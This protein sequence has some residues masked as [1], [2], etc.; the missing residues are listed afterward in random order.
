VIDDGPVIAAGSGA[1]RPL[2]VQRA[3]RAPMSAE[4]LVRG[5]PIAKGT[6]LP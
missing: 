4:E 2:Q 5:F 1:I 3:G 6:I